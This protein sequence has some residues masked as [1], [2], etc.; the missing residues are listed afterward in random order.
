VITVQI[1]GFGTSQLE[2]QQEESLEA[3]YKRFKVWEHVHF[4]DSPTMRD[5]QTGKILQGN[6]IMIDNRLY[7]LT[8][9]LE[10]E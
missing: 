7:D 3:F 1:G 8:V 10:P 2:F 4:K 5:T 6:E 9:W